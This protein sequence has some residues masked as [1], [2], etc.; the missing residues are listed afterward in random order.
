M[1]G[2][3]ITSHRTISKYV[4][5]DFPGKTERMADRLLR[6]STSGLSHTTVGWV[7]WD[8][9]SDDWRGSSA[10]ELSN[11]WYFAI[12]FPFYVF[13]LYLV[14]GI[15]SLTGSPCKRVLVGLRVHTFSHRRFWVKYIKLSYLK[16]IEFFQGALPLQLAICP[17]YVP[18]VDMGVSRWYHTRYH[19]IRSTRHQMTHQDS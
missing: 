10:E 18:G 7:L 14:P 11:T 1:S 15:Y 17:W 9:N 12:P 6:I 4:S 8:L 13:P 2:Y 5:K 16:L 3:N 19:N